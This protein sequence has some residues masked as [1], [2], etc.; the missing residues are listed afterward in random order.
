M[1]WRDIAIQMRGEIVKGM[2]KHFLQF[3]NFNN[4]QFSD[5]S[6]IA[7]NQGIKESSRNKESMKSLQ[8]IKG[9]MDD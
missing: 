2:R 3:W 4:I 6:G 1:P 9:D 7:Q 8:D 5:K